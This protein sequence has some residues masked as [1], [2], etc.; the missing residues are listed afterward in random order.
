MKIS[1]NP[2]Q[3]LATEDGWVDFSKG[4]PLEEMATRL[5]AA[6]FSAVHTDVPPDMA[7][8]QYRAVLD[9]HG[10]TPAPGYFSG[11]L[12]D[13]QG[14]E[15]VVAQATRVARQHQALGLRELFVAADLTQTRVL[16]PAQ[17]AD[18]STARLADIVRSLGA[19]GQATL[20]CGVTSCLHPHVGTWI[21]TEE[22]IE[23]VLT[24]LDPEVVALG[25][26]TGHLAWAGVDPLE[27]VGRHRDRVRSLHVKDIRLGIAA[28]FRG[29]AVPYRDVVAA[30]LWVEPGRGDLDLRAIFQRLSGSRCEWAVVEVDFPDL[31]IPAS[32]EACADWALEAESW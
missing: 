32:I 1:I 11:A 19:V 22:E 7:V 2:L 9:R 14:R 25:P 29:K 26:D 31:D 5:S 3:W 17:G 27:L 16:V 20:E 28:E 10:L 15:T 23:W 21:E 4:L 24:R 18:P 8:E 12:E 30:G 6:G 13:G